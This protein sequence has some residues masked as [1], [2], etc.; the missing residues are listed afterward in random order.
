MRAKLT[1]FVSMVLASAI[2]GAE[3]DLELA[4]MGALVVIMLLGAAGSSAAREIVASAIT[5]NA[6]TMIDLRRVPPF[7]GFVAGRLGSRFS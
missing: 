6:T 5:A 4:T 7:N 2:F 3:T 1:N